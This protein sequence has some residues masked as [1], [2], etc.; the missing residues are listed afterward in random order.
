[1][2]AVEGGAQLRET[3]LRLKAAGDVELWKQLRRNIRTATAPARPA[4]RASARANLP[5][6]GGLNEWV[7][8]ASITTSILTGPHTAGVRLR[9][10][11][12][13]HN[14]QDVDKGSVRHPLFG[15]RNYWYS[16]PVTPGFARKPVEELT[17]AVAAA[18]LLAMRET[19]AA[20]GFH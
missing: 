17:P 14:M 16:N 15:N 7:A 5:K 8:T 19:A 4:I 3:A 9:V 20:A 12:R 11:K 2:E 18:C 13:G 10:R 1:M 6:Q